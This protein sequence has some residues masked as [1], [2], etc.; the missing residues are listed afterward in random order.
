MS[1]ADR[2]KFPELIPQ[3]VAST[4]GSEG[5]K[6]H[7]GVIQITAPRRPAGHYENEIQFHL[8]YAT[9]SFFHI[10]PNRS[11]KRQ[12]LYA[13]GKDCHFNFAPDHRCELDVGFFSGRAMGGGQ[14]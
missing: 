10:R 5:A 8:D 11:Q 1:R 7:K 9:S 2:R 3:A 4:W 12:S 14:R 6:A 13:L